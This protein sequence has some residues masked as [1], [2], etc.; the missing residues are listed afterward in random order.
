MHDD[1]ATETF[2]SDPMFRRD[3]NRHQVRIFKCETGKLMSRFGSG[4]LA[5]VK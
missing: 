2:K 4:I 3:F 5:L 1:A